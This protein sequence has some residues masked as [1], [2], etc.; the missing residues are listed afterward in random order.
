MRKRLLLFLT[1]LPLSLVAAHVGK[2]PDFASRQVGVPAR[3]I[4]RITPDMLVDISDE[5]LREDIA[6]VDIDP[7]A[8][9]IPAEKP[10]PRK[11]DA[12]DDVEFVSERDEF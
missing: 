9:D 11:K 3:E 1:A 7:E 10:K 4:V 5:L 12:L 6:I 2:A 8:F